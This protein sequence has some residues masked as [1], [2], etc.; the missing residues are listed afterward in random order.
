LVADEWLIYARLQSASAQAWR[1]QRKP[2][3]SF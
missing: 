3:G 1:D 2:F